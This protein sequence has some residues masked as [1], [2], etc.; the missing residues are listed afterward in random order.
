[1]VSLNICVSHWASG[2]SM[3]SIFYCWSWICRLSRVQ[4]SDRLLSTDVH[5]LAH[6]CNE[7]E[8]EV[9][10]SWLVQCVEKTTAPVGTVTVTSTPQ[11]W[12][13]KASTVP[14]HIF[15]VLMKW[16]LF[17]I[18]SL[19]R[20]LNDMQWNQKSNKQTKKKTTTLP[21]NPLF[22]FHW[23]HGIPVVVMEA[24]HK[25]VTL[26][27]LL[28]R[29][30]KSSNH[31]NMNLMICILSNVSSCLEQVWKTPQFAAWG[32]FKTCSEV[33]WDQGLPVVAL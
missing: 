16:L 29:F 23:E 17:F 13:T 25:N 3:L 10:S 21:L 19:N 12:A 22:L 7:T 33:R 26:R 8:K 14:E 30:G 11:V 4:K 27:Q 2:F 9:S 6:I 15:F 28:W 1:M 24:K 5:I 31:L 18:L 32:H 20:K